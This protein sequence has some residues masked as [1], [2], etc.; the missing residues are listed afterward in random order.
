M[1]ILLS[2]VILLLVGACYLRKVIGAELFSTLIAAPIEHLTG[3]RTVAPE[4][5]IYSIQEAQYLADQQFRQMFTAV[6]AVG[7]TAN[8]F[9]WLALNYEIVLMPGKEASDEGLHKSIAIETRNFIRKHHGFDNPDIYVPV[10]TGSEMTIQI[11]C[12]GKAHEA[13]RKFNFSTQKPK[14]P[15]IQETII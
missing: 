8:H 15:D 1:I 12:S 10:L 5:G 3:Y 9:G 4:Q 13:A 6:T 7:I 11:A 2:T 14:Q